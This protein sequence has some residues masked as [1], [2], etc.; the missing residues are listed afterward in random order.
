[1]KHPYLSK[2]LPRHSKPAELTDC[3]IGDSIY[4]CLSLLLDGY[5]LNRTEYRVRCL[6]ELVG[7]KKLHEKFMYSNQTLATFSG[8][9]AD[10]V[11]ES[12]TEN[13]TS[14]FWHATAAANILQRPI[15]IRVVP[16]S[17]TP[18]GTKFSQILSKSR[19][20]PLQKIVKNRLTT[21]SELYF[22]FR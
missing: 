14:S 6:L 16:I 18:Q 21:R 1:M 20:F 8:S 7:N 10:A 13:G 9:Y 12:L 15:S 3:P 2:D 5:L 19:I 22:L 11:K 17:Q 4:G